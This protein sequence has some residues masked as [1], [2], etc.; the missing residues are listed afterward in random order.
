VFNPEQLQAVLQTLGDPIRRLALEG[1]EWQTH[2]RGELHV[3][4]EY[5]EHESYTIGADTSAGIRGRDYSVATVLD[6][7]KRQV[8]VLRGYFA[9]DY[10][11]DLLYHLGKF[12]NYA[13]IAPRTTTTAF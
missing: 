12:Y 8:A 4:K 7:R 3:Y 11:A 1:D 5:D 9:P 2:P 6:R 10:F 13:L